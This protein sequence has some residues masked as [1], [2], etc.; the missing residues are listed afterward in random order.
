MVSMIIENNQRLDELLR[1]IILE[2][3]LVQ[4]GSFGM[5]DGTFIGT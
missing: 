5:S 2:P 4:K 3:I 1:Y